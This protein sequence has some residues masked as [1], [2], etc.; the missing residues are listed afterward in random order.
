MKVPIIS[1]FVGG[2]I[3]TPLSLVNTKSL[4]ISCNSSHFVKSTCY[5][6]VTKMLK[7]E[8]LAEVKLIAVICSV[9]L[10]WVITAITAITVFSYCKWFEPRSHIHVSW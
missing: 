10:L 7:T 6:L 8:H 3:G 1:C 4:I 5:F 9:H 2:E